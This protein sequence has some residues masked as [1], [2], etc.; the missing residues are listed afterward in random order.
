MVL[1]PKDSTRACSVPKSRTGPWPEPINPTQHPKKTDLPQEEEEE[2]ETRLIKDLKR[3]ANSLSRDTRQANALGLEGGPPPLGNC[4]T[5][6]KGFTGR[7]L[8]LLETCE[9]FTFGI[10]AVQNP[11]HVSPVVNYTS[12]KP[13]IFETVATVIHSAG[14]SLR[15]PTA[16]GEQGT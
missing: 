4:S 2:E 15:R 8:S 5:R 13:T 16:P 6:L 11:G 14:L 9:T 1:G 10:I 7:V 3:K 12:F